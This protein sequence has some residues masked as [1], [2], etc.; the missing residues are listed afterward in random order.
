MRAMSAN[1]SFDKKSVTGAVAG[2]SHQEDLMRTNRRLAQLWLDALSNG[3]RGLGRYH[4]HLH[5]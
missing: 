2:S 3:A 1:N 4:R 5:R